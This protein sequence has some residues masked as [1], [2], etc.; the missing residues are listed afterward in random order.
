MNVLDAALI[1]RA[2]WTLLHSVWQLAAAALVFALLT[3]M[4][5]RSLSSSIRYAAACAAMLV[6]LLCPLVTWFVV[7]G[8]ATNDSAQPPA[9]EMAAAIGSAGDANV[10]LAPRSGQARETAAPPRPSIA[11]CSWWACRGRAPPFS[12]GCWRNYHSTRA[13]NTGWV[14]IPCPAPPGRTG[15]QSQPTGKWNNPWRCWN[16]STPV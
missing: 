16:R 3:A 9:S 10:Q 5:P 11:P 15:R 7:A 13:W 14:A 1:D 2:G 8:S 4:A 6:M 12:T